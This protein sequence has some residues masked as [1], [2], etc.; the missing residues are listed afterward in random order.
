MRGQESQKKMVLLKFPLKILIL[1]NRR[2]KRQIRVPDG[3]TQESHSGI[4]LT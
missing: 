2:I 3:L 4:K 1:I